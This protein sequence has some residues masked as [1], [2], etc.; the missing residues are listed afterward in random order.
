MREKGRIEIGLLIAE[1]HVSPDTASSAAD[2]PAW[3][4][5]NCQWEG[6]FKKV[7]RVAYIFSSTMPLAWDAP[8]KGFFHS[9]PR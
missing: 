3:D 5:M 6:R 2:M 8:A 7:C 1:P 4:P 9:F